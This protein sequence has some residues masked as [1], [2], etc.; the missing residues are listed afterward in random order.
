MYVCID[1]L[2]PSP[3]VRGADFLF[4][5]TLSSFSPTTSTSQCYQVTILDDLVLE[6]TEHLEAE[7]TAPGGVARVSVGTSVVRA[8]IIDDDSVMVGFSQTD[9]T[10]DE[11]EPQAL[12]VSVC[13]EMVG[14]L[15]RE[16]SVSVASERGSA[17]GECEK[18]TTS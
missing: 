7:L 13:V 16:V 1:S 8:A 2:S 4:T 5:T 6:D 9:F 17:D 18:A 10:V 15:E 3:A 14:E 11:D 12:S